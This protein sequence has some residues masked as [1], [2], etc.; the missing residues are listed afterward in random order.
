MP[1][2]QHA[3]RLVVPQA[4]SVVQPVPSDAGL[5][6]QLIVLSILHAVRLVAQPVRSVAPAVQQPMQQVL[7][8]ALWAMQ[9]KAL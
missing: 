2:I 9:L 3:M 4:R 6:M 5:A 8:D 1:Q 7:P